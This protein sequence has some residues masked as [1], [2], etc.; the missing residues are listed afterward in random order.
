MGGVRDFVTHDEITV[1]IYS[2]FT[3][4]AVGKFYNAVVVGKKYFLEK[5]VK[6][7]LKKTVHFLQNFL[8]ASQIV[9]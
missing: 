6:Q 4:G 2:V 9:N 8:Q 5:Q 7:Q 3:V 1:R